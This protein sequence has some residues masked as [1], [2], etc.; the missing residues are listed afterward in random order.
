MRRCWAAVAERR[1]KLILKKIYQD[2]TKDTRLSMKDFEH[3]QAIIDGAGDSV[4]DLQAYMTD[5]EE[6][7]EENAAEAEN[8]ISN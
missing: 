6:D 8:A 7:G 4:E 3:E 5:N 2:A 1:Q